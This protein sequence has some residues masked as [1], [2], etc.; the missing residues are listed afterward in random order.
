MSI[1]HVAPNNIRTAMNILGSKWTALIISELS[2]GS[3]RFGQLEKSI[4]GINPRTLSSRLD[5]LETERIIKSCNDSTGRCHRCY[6]LTS[7]GR[8]LMP[9]LQKMAQWGEKYPNDARQNIA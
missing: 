5:D 9:I 2:T 8:D 6:S 3:K 7:K 4:T 1:N